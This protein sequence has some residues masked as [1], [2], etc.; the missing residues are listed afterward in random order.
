[1]KKADAIK[2]CRNRLV[3]RD[4]AGKVALVPGTSMTEFPAPA[5]APRKPI[6]A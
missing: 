1:M 4:R 6:D 5:V 3:W 2:R